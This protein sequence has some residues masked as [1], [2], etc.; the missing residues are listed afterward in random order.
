[1][2]WKNRLKESANSKFKRAWNNLTL[3]GRHLEAYSLFALT[4]PKGFTNLPAKIQTK[5][6]E[7]Y[8]KLLGLVR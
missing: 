4:Q 3:Q 6:Y 2:D 7:D 5:H 1:M 8:L